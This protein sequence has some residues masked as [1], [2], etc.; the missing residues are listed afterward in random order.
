MKNTYRK[1]EKLQFV[2]YNLISVSKNMRDCSWVNY[3]MVFWSLYFCHRQHFLFFDN[4]QS[5]LRPLT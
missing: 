4:F 2:P 1:A 3:H 5:Y